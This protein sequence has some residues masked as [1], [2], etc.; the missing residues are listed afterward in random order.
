MNGWIADPA[1]DV[2]EASRLTA[3]VAELGNEDAIALTFGGFALGH[4]VGDL[5]KGIA[6]V[7]KARA[8]N[9][10]FATAWCASGTLRAYRGG[11]PDV[12]VEHLAQA[13]LLSPFDPLMFAMQGMTAYGHFNAGRHQEAIAWA[14]KA[15]HENPRILLTLRIAAACNVAAGRLEEARS[16]MVRALEIDP[17]MRVSNLNV[18]L[19]KFHRPEDRAR[20]VDCLRKAGLP[21]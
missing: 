4:V 13:M 2:A 1:R 7:D 19:P 12:V 14:E 8:L 10:N 17:E 21:E 20:Y 11:E 5:D 18:R 3:R 9:P 6:L 16:A 15:V